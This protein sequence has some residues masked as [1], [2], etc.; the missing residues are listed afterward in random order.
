MTSTAADDVASHDSSPSLSVNPM[1]DAAGPSN[2]QQVFTYPSLFYV[3]FL[4]ISEH[5]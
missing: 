3:I 5:L 1:D 2:T 4:F